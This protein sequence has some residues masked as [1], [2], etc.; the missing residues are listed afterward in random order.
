MQ[1]PLIHSRR[2]ARC[3][4]F[5]L[6]I[7]LTLSQRAYAQTAPDAGA[8]PEPR[9]QSAPMVDEITARVSRVRALSVRGPIASGVLSRDE[10]L[11]R[12]RGRIAQEYQADELARE[13]LL[14][15]TLGLWNDPQGYVDLTF[16]I[17][18]EQVAGFY[19][20]STRRLYVASWLSPLTQGPTLAHELTHALQDQH[21]DISRFTHH[22]RGSGDRQLAAMTIIEGDA[23]LAMLAFLQG[24][25]GIADRA[26]AQSVAM[27][28]TRGGGE[29]LARAPLVL[30]ESLVFPY[31]E[32]LSVCAD[33]YERGG[34]RAIN[35]LLRDPPQSTEQILH[36]DKLAQREAPQ[37][38]TVALPPSLA[39]THELAYEETFGELGIR[40]WIA[41]W[42]SANV[43]ESAAAG[44]GG[45]RAALFVARGT[46]PVT[47]R[48]PAVSLWKIAMDATPFDAE[49]L[50]LERAVIAQLRAR[51]P[52][53]RRVT[54]AGVRYAV[55][56]SATTVALVARQG[57]TLLV[58][59]GVPTR[60]AA[61]VVRETL[62]G[63][64]P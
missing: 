55:T 53:A 51:Y 35:A 50:E 13:G 10:I 23:T 7:A 6:T 36:P 30:R 54:L 26:R 63:L 38:I 18:E 39:S 2:F 12:L 45:D 42:L 25:A 20:P 3:A 62:N 27:R 17:L 1:N 59:D 47:E 43:A 48:T 31:R 32:G 41:T 37:E 34:W 15:R 29:R 46:T 4:A 9:A 16:S 11:A 14:F 56:T 44:W 60:L 28:D 33:A 19:D 5:S 52:R 21:F 22:V 64:T 49:A 40:L 24:G 8:A 57:S 61:S 58:G